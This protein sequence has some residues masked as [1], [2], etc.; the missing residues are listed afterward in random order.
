M[1]GERIINVEKMFNLRHGAQREDDDLSDRFTE[2]RVPG[3]SGSYRHVP[4]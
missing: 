4:V 3:D 2:E 1:T